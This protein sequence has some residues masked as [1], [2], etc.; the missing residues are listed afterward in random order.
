MPKSYQIFWFVVPNVSL[1]NPRLLLFTATIFK[2]DFYLYWFNIIDRID[3]WKKCTGNPTVWCSNPWFHKPSIEGHIFVG[4]N[5]AS[6]FII[7]IPT[8]NWCVKSLKSQEKSWCNQVQPG[9]I[10]TKIMVST[11][12]THQFGWNPPG[13]ALLAARGAIRRRRPGA[14]RWR[15]LRRAEACDGTGGFHH[16]KIDGKSMGRWWGFHLDLMLISDV[17]I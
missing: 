7:E 1:K 6:C 3:L 5:A 9:E 4:K 2:T 10:P 17:T 11:S 15:T 14:W 13:S 16:G 12:F 8:Q